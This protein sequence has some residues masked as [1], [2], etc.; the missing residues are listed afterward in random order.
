MKENKSTRYKV[1]GTR[2]PDTSLVRAAHAFA[3]ERH[4]GQ[5][6]KGD[7]KPFIS[8]PVAVARILAA[9]R[10]PEKVV[11]AALLHDVL[12]DTPT[13][14]AELER[15]FGK[16]VASLV[17]EVTEPPRRY[18]WEYRKRAYL[19][20]LKKASRGALAISCADKL[21]NTASLLAAYKK[22]GPLVFERFSRGV[23]RKLEY[24]REVC[25][26]VRAAWPGCPFLPRLDRMLAQL[27]RISRDEL[28][29]E[30][31][32]VEAKF[33]VRDPAIFGKLGKLKELGRFRLKSRDVEEQDNRYLDTEDMRL[34]QARAILKTRRAGGKLDMTFK[35]ELSYRGGVSERIEVRS[36]EEALPRARK[37][38]GSRPLK[39]ILVLRT[40]RD[41]LIFARG[42]HR[43]EL[44]LDQVAVRRGGKNV[45]TFSE[46]EVENLSAPEAEFQ[47]ALRRV[48]RLGG[49]W[50][51]ASRIPKVEMGLRLLK[52]RGNS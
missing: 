2:L 6:R 9:A 47:E 52:R 1:P 43:V 13:R 38:V 16:E 37:I 34:R 35:R 7:G 48:R 28:R 17:R 32:E 19:R 14:P 26:T 21:H 25:E 27:E 40:R 39:E 12:E 50:L 31:K 24:H 44:D 30:P 23:D 33:I 22:E 49:K 3:A 41:R 46:V 51:R 4:A 15:R 42:K 5:L 8:H 29:K 20:H 45:A 18:S 10:L 36:P 11:A